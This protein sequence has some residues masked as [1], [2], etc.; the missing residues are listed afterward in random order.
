MVDSISKAGDPHSL[1]WKYILL[2]RCQHRY[3][4]C[5]DIITNKLPLEAITNDLI[6]ATEKMWTRVKQVFPFRGI[7]LWNHRKLYSSIYRSVTMN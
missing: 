1:Q 7:Q 2:H 4:W 3:C 6:K 5:I